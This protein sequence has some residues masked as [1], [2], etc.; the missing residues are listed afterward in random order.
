MYARDQNME[1]HILTLGYFLQTL[2]V[3]PHKQVTAVD[4]R[5]G[6]TPTPSF[7]LSQPVTHTHTQWT[8]IQEL[9]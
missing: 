1:G 8:I 3:A 7:E 9:Y 2:S 5:L 4:D 6:N